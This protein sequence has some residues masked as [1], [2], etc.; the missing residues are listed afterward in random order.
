[1]ASSEEYW[2]RAAEAQAAAEAEAEERALAFAAFVKADAEAR[3]ARHVERIK[4]KK[5]DAECN[6][7]SVECRYAPVSTEEMQRVTERK[8]RAQRRASRR[9][10]SSSPPGEATAART[11]Y[12]AQNGRD[13]EI[14]QLCCDWKVV[15]G[16]WNSMLAKDDRQE[17]GQLKSDT[18]KPTKKIA[19]DSWN[20]NS[21]E[22]KEQES[23]S[24]ITASFAFP[25]TETPA[26]LHLP[27]PL[28]QLEPTPTKLQRHN[29]PVTMYAHC[30]LVPPVPPMHFHQLSA[31]SLNL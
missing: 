13:D 19:L 12:S 8:A 10:A 25:I 27:P 1:M 30:D 7:V 11:F 16:G 21:H 15:L 9:M 20:I 14:S 17:P 2:R 4:A 22:V 29:T 23:P 24:S 28:S 18:H 26:T 31:E 3:M 5:R 6:Q